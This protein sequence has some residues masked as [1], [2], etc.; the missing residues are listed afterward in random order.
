MIKLKQILFSISILALGQYCNVC[1]AMD[2]PADSLSHTTKSSTSKKEDTDEVKVFNRI[3]LKAISSNNF[4][5]DSK[6]SIIEVFNSGI[7]NGIKQGISE[8]T[9][10]VIASLFRFLPS[11]IKRLGHLFAAITYK[12]AFG[13]SPLTASVL[14][15]MSNRIHYLINPFTILSVGKMDKKRRA[16]LIKE[17]QE[18]QTEYNQNWIYIKTEL[19]LELEHAI[20]FLQRSLACYDLFCFNVINNG[21]KYKLAK[22]IYSFSVEDCVQISFYINRTVTYI[23]K[24]VELFKSFKSEEEAFKNYEEIKRWL[25]WVCHSFE[26][27]SLFLEDNGSKPQNR[28]NFSKV[29]LESQ[30]GLSALETLLGPSLPGTV[31]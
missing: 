3:L 29:N 1:L 14:M 26:Q 16:T 31:G 12:Y 5:A 15:R 10:E 23:T 21:L 4:D 24:L 6:Y 13:A 19:L 28:M 22:L 7:K 11:G 20:K 18:K 8:T 27:I 17:E 9:R 2:D 25:G 30:S